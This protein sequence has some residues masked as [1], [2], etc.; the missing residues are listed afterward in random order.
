ML[1]EDMILCD[2]E[3]NKLDGPPN[4]TQCYEVKIHSCI[5]KA[6]PDVKAIVHVHPQFTVLMTILGSPIHVMAGGQA[7]N[8]LKKPVNMM[9]KYK[10]IQSE[11][12]GQQV[13]DTLADNHAMLLLGHGVVVA[14]D[15]MDEVVVGAL[16]FEEQAKM[17]YYAYSAAG[18][19]YPRIPQDLVDEAF[20]HTIPFSDLPHFQGQ[21]AEQHRGQGN[22]IFNHYAEIVSRDL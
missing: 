13:A 7:I 14:G 20:Y 3:G 8:I 22:A 10:I 2:L 11:E 16:G 15:S 6:R 17:N 9:R 12:E 21:N 4:G 5:Y 18:P 1:P 19:N